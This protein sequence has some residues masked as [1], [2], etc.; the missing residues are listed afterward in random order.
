MTL[1]GRVTNRSGAPV[2]EVGVVIWRSTVILRSAS[3]VADALEAERSPLG[4]PMAEIPSGVAKLTED[5]V[6]L[7]PG[8]SVPFT[9]QARLSELEPRRKRDLLG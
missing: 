2:H 3:V 5:G 8:E 1:S 7:S 4:K 9:V 6:K